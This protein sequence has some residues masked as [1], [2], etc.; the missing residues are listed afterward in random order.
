MNYRYTKKHLGIFLILILCLS[1]VFS[2]SSCNFFNSNSSKSSTTNPAIFDA[3][4]K[5]IANTTDTIIIEESDIAIYVANIVIPST[6]EITCT[7]N[8]T[9]TRTSGFGWGGSSSNVSSSSSCQ[10]TGMVINEDGY[11]LT[12]AHV[13]TLES[14]S[15]YQNLSYTSWDIK[16]NYADQTTYYDAD[17]IAYDTALDLAILKMDTVNL[18]EVNYVTFFDL[19]DP[20]TDAYYEDDAVVLYYGEQ[21]Y[22]VG[23]ANGYGISITSGLV[24]API[25]LFQQTSD[26]VKAIQTDAAINSGNSGG[27]LTNKYGVVI[28]INSFKIVTS[29]SENLG[30]AIPTYVILPFIEQVNNNAASVMV[31]NNQTI[32]YYVTTT[33]AYVA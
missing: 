1:L 26:V 33:R 25:R 14:E 30:Y 3:N 18:T 11:V 21:A 15:S 22:V 17:L 19:T 24:S 20:T 8:F 9:Y 5:T 10:A 12:N 16:L 23:N 7:I 32:K 27:P 28:G 4:N 2:L 29:T 13:V 6:V 31:K